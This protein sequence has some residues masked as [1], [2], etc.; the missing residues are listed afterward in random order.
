[1]KLRP[2]MC[3]FLRAAASAKTS[4][5][6]CVPWGGGEGEAGTEAGAAEGEKAA[7][8]AES[9]DQKSAPAESKAEKKDEGKA[10][11]SSDKK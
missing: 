9:K 6:V 8:G 2:R 3:A 4:G 10:K 1:M 5:N 11:Q 7:E